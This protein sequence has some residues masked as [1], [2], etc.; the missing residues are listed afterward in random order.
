MTK[1]KPITLTELVEG[2][3]PQKKESLIHKYFLSKMT[4]DEHLAWRRAAAEKRKQTNA[5]KREKQKELIEQ[6]RTLVPE[7]IAHQ[8][9][10]EDMDKENW[11]PSQDMID[12][13]K[14]LVKSN[15]TIEELRTKYF[16]RVQDKTWHKLMKFVF[17]SQVSQ[18]EDLGADILRVKNSRVKM[19]KK[20]K[21]EVEKQ[22]KYHTQQTGKK[23]LPQY[24]LQMGMDIDKEL[25]TLELDVAKTL[26]QVGAV[27]EKSKSPSLNI[28][29]TIPRPPKKEKEVVEAE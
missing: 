27:G 5:A 2:P 13:V 26:F 22:K 29:M 11:V 15:L 12:K 16:S 19:L 10:A 18:S 1:P 17:K 9:A 23:V 25:M 8:L 4:P 20:Q 14:Q 3:T 6:A 21:R 7:I 24:L 28:H